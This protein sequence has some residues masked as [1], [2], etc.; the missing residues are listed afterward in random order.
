[1]E[2]LNL[3][4]VCV[5]QGW[6]MGAGAEMVWL[7][8][9]KGAEQLAPAAGIALCPATLCCAWDPRAE[10]T[11]A[12]DKPYIS[13]QVVIK[14]VCKWQIR[15]VLTLVLTSTKRRTLRTKIYAILK[16]ISWRSS[17]TKKQLITAWRSLG[18]LQLWR[19]EE[20]S[21][22]RELQEK[23][24]QRNK[25]VCEQGALTVLR[26]A[27]GPPCPAVPSHLPT[28]HWE[29]LCQPQAVE[30]QPQSTPTHSLPAQLLP[31][32]TTGGILPKRRHLWVSHSHSHR[33]TSHI[34][35]EMEIKSC[36][37]HH[38]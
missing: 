37:I 15:H 8:R 28:H 12:R 1:M 31:D 11:A 14:P 13:V 18:G 6:R 29:L 30:L 10:P 4:D 33:L 24:T 25:G 38:F 26:A 17:S 5:Q 23:G 7:P 21:G 35:E 3:G 22:W 32:S 20:I 34:Q 19:M 9:V 16:W 2:L 36:A 27:H